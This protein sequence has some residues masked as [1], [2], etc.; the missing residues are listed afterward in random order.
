MF[1]DKE[2]DAIQDF[3]LSI[4]CIQMNYIFPNT[5]LDIIF[6]YNRHSNLEK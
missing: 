3:T 4:A 5:T 1:L 2:L 6:H